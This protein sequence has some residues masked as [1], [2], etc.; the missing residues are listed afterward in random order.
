VSS[1]SG[2][3]DLDAAQLAAGFGAGSFSPVEV[4]R[5]VLDAAEGTQ[6]TLNA[7][8][9]LDPDGA[10]TAAT[11]SEARWRAGAALGPYDGVPISVKDNLH[12]EGMPTRFGSLA[13]PPERTRGP[14]SPAVARMREAGAVLFGK[15]SMPEFAHK[16][17]TD[18][19]LTGVTRNPHN[20]AHT[21][22]GSSGGAGAAVAAGIG[23]LAI[24]SDG[25]G[26]IRIPAAWTG[27]FGLKPSLGRVPH[28]PR[29]PLVSFSHV[30]PMTRTVADAAR[31]MA[32]LSLPDSRDWYSL[33]PEA[34][35]PEAVLVETLAGV[36]IAFSPRLGLSDLSVDPEIEAA[37]AAAAAVF[38][39]LGAQVE[40]ADPPL[41]QDCAR[42][43][44]AHLVT[45]SAYTLRGLPEG[46]QVD[47]SFRALADRAAELPPHAYLDATID[48]GAV[49]SQINQFF[50]RYDL[51]L[52]PVVPFGPPAVDGLDPMQVFDPLMTQ[53]CNVTGLP[54]ASV[55]CG[56]M[57]GGLPIGLQIVGRR[58]DDAG[59][60][61]ASHAYE[62]ARARV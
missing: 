20:Q 1:R 42:I 2:L 4:A 52:S 22:G 5:A 61:R 30:G 41:V 46:A 49:G 33:P 6:A 58:F 59:V 9:W 36:R 38:E 13:L 56:V 12:V 21:P 31:A 27:L 17:T 32:I 50:E 39:T 23:P 60:L 24:A 28:H 26:S 37:V 10:L 45:F 29:G 43:T 35:D 7:F 44:D 55:P 48:R 19:P 47:P 11:G 34:F 8:A 57:Q 16:M 25:A 3:C 54:A 62:Q 15:T 51:V 14:D 53:W 40:L 18:S